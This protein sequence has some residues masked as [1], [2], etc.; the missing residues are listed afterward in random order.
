MEKISCRQD[1]RRERKQAKKQAIADLQ[2][3]VA[4]G[5]GSKYFRYGL[6]LMC[7]QVLLWN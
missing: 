4:A 1:K 6:I 3:K 2:V 5:D 7:L